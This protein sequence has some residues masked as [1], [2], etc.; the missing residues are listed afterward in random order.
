[1]AQYRKAR[2]DKVVRSG[3][4]SRFEDKRKGRFYDHSVYPVHDATGR[5]TAVAVFARDMTSKK[6]GQQAL[7]ARERELKTKAR[8]PE[9]M[10]IA[11]KALLKRRDEDK[12]ELEE[13]VLYN[14]KELVGPYLEKLKRSRLDARQESSMALLFCLSTDCAYYEG[15]QTFTSCYHGVTLTAINGDSRNMQH[16]VHQW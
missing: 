9:E 4:P 5:V 15:P 6:R 1:V 14:V 8:N 13:K 12:E 2:V 7:K 3:K 10:N 11:L 16:Y